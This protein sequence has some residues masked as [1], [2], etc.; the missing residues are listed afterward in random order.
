MTVIVAVGVC[1]GFAVIVAVLVR[2]AAGVS[3]R[4][5][6]AVAVAVIAGAFS[7][8][9]VI[10]MG[11]ELLRTVTLAGAE[12]DQRG[13]GRNDGESAEKGAHLP[14]PTRQL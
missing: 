7:V 9:A 6:L 1:F 8:P 13:G 2:Q 10:A 4:S 14:E 12:E 11:A 3:V 5:F